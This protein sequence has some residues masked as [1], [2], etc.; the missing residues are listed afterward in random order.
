MSLTDLADLL[1]THTD[2]SFGKLFSYFW[3]FA[4]VVDDWSA[5][6]LAVDSTSTVG[7]N[8]VEGKKWSKSF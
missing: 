7:I 8:A 6:L 2:L 3:D 5:M 1:D 4:T